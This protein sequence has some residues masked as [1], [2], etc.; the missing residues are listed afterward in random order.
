MWEHTKYMFT[1]ALYKCLFPWT[2]DTWMLL[3]LFCL[4]FQKPQVDHDTD[5]ETIFLLLPFISQFNIGPQTTHTKCYTVLF[6]SSSASLL[7]FYRMK[8]INNSILSNLG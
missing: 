8:E 5:S 1:S 4:F 3:V 7:V 2:A 6:T